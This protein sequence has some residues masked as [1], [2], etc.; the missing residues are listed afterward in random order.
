VRIVQNHPDHRVYPYKATF[1]AAVAGPQSVG[2][3]IDLTGGNYRTMFVF[4]AIFMALAGVLMLRMRE[5]LAAVVET[6]QGAVS[7]G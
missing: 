6:A 1:I 4:G 3:L 2:V 5:N 7:P